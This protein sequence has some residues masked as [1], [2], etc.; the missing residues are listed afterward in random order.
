MSTPASALSAF[1]FIDFVIP[2]SAAF[3]KINPVA[4]MMLVIKRPTLVR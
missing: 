3:S 1:N 4:F 2:E